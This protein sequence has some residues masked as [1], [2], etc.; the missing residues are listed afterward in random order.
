VGSSLEEGRAG[1][2]VH[3]TLP[4][5]RGE[6]EERVGILTPGARGG[7][8]ARTA[9]RRRR[10]AAVEQARCESAQGARVR[11]GERG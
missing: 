9:G 5:R 10:E 3:G 8:G 6:Q 4:W 1:I 7:G 2:L 11:R